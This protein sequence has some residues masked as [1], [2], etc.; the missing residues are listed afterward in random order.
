MASKATG[1]KK[2]EPSARD[3][4]SEDTF[5][6]EFLVQLDDSKNVPDE[7]IEDN[8]K[9]VVL[10]AEQRGLRADG[11]VEL[12]SKEVQDEHNVLLAYTLPVKPAT[13]TF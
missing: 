8:K 2:T 7:L 13:E 11:E 10:E 6:K 12:E 9:A 4:S 1:T 5:A 3:K